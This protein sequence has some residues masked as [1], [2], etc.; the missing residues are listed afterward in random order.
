MSLQSE[1]AAA[2][3]DPLAQLITELGET[4]LLR[5][6]NEG[7]A[8]DGSKTSTIDRVPGVAD[9]IGL[10]P[11][12]RSATKRRQD[13]GTDVGIELEAYVLNTVLMQEGDVIKLHSGDFSG[14]YLAA[15]RSRREPAGGVNLWA[16]TLAVDLDALDQG[17]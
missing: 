15:W 17:F 9:P 5:R 8:A 10:L 16:F 12:T 11:V 13:W 4:A 3:A 14:K 6:P 1:L 7:E 2:L